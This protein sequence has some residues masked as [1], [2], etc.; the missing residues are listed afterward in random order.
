MKSCIGRSLTQP[1]NIFITICTAKEPLF[2]FSVAY[3]GYKT[4]A[5][6]GAFHPLLPH[7]PP[8]ASLKI[9]PPGS[10]KA[11]PGSRAGRRKWRVKAPASKNKAHEPLTSLLCSL[12]IINSILCPSGRA[13]GERFVKSKLTQN[14]DNPVEL[15]Q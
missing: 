14:R 11:A 6:Q 10:E 9:I 2:Q 13:G 1:I 7:H 4:E 3:K 8:Q 15:R 12:S 5:E